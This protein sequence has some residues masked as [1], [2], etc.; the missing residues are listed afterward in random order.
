MKSTVVSCVILNVCDRMGSSV[1]E[2]ILLTYFDWFW[3]KP[4]MGPTLE[5]GGMSKMI[6]G[7]FQESLLFIFWS[8]SSIQITLVAEEHR[9]VVCKPLEPSSRRAMAVKMVQR[10]LY[11]MM[12]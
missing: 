1:S 9:L 11:P 4:K 8:Q 3:D 12:K 5:K 2:G 7:N 10:A 6:S